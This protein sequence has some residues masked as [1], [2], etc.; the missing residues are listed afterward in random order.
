MLVNSSTGNKKISLPRILNEG[1]KGQT[2]TP[3]DWSPDGKW[4][5][6]SLVDTNWIAKIALISPKDGSMKVLKDVGTVI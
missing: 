3:Y 1:S 5:L 6:A 4:I 2:A